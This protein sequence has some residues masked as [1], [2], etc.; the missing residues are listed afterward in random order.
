MG[1]LLPRGTKLASLI[2]REKNL[3]VYQQCVQKKIE[4]RCKEKLIQNSQVE[5]VEGGCSHINAEGYIIYL[6]IEILHAH[7]S[8]TVLVCLTI[9]NSYAQIWVN[10]LYQSW[11]PSIINT[12]QPTYMKIA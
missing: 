3:R 1:E 6:F 9:N 4:R 7:K 11:H 2:G 12:V 8:Y 5:V 10:S